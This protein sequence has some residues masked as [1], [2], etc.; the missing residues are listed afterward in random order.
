[1]VEPRGHC[2]D[3]HGEQ[4]FPANTEE[5]TGA[6][7]R[8]RTREGQRGGDTE[9]RGETPATQVKIDGRRS[10]GFVFK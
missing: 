6:S 3:T 4:Q 9:H 2:A 5:G 10:N 1:M 7:D 8:E